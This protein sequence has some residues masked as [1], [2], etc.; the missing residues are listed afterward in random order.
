MEQLIKQITERTGISEEQ[1]KQAVE[2][3][4]DFLKGQLPAGLGSQLDNVISGDLSS[5]GSIANQAQGALGGLFG[6][7]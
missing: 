5:L 7:K 6:K 2:T 1:A 4:L 3:V